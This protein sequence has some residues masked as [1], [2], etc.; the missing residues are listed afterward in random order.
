MARKATKKKPVWERGY[1]RSHVLWQGKEKLAKVQLDADSELK[2][3]WEAKGRKGEASTLSAAKAAG[4]GR[5]AFSRAG[6][7]SSSILRLAGG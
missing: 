2:Y 4:P 3:L 6:D 5:S 1:N 7:H